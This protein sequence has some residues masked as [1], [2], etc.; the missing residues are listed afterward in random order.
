MRWK[1]GKTP[2]I[3]SKSFGVKMNYWVRQELNQLTL[4]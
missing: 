3:S 1:I 2:Y 4:N